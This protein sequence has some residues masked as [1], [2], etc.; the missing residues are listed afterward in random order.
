MGAFEFAVTGIISDSEDLPNQYKLYPNF[1]NPFNPETR[2][3]FSLP[4]AGRV[5]L[6]IFNISGQRIQTIVDE[7]KPAG[8]YEVYFNGKNRASGLYFYRLNAGSFI[9]TGR[10]ILVK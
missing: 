5:K 7:F 9:R 8:M 10:M 2:I 6:E 1:P 3:R 4:V